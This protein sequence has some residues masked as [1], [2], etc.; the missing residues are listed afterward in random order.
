MYL[1][2]TPAP[3]AMPTSETEAMPSPAAAPA[4]GAPGFLTL[5]GVD[6]HPEALRTAAGATNTNSTYP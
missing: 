1:Y 4:D 3:E 2:I 5:L 6:D